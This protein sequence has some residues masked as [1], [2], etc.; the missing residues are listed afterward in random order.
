VHSLQEAGTISVSLA[1]LTWRIDLLG[2]YPT[3]ETL[4]AQGVV[5][6]VVGILLILAARTARSVP[7]G[8]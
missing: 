5:I 4:V 1:N 7:S 2:I 6:V 8:T 3:V